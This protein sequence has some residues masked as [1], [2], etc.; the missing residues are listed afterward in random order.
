MCVTESTR[1]FL[2]LKV[3]NRKYSLVYV[4]LPRDSMF[5]LKMSASGMLD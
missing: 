1:V 4:D 3:T 2:F 5:E